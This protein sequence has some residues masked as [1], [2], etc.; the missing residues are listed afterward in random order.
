MIRFLFLTCLFFL[1]YCYGYGN[2][3]GKTIHGYL[4]DDN[5]E[6]NIKCGEEHYD[7]TNDFSEYKCKITTN[8]INI[9]WS[10]I[11][12]GDCRY[13]DI[14]FVTKGVFYIE[15]GIW[16]ENEILYYQYDNQLKNWFLYKKVNK[17]GAMDGPDSDAKPEKVTKL[18]EQWS[19]D[20]QLL[21]V[22]YAENAIK[23]IRLVKNKY[24][25]KLYNEILAI[26]KA[27]KLDTFKLTL[28]NVVEYNNLAF[29][30]QQVGA[31]TQAITILKNIITKFPERDVAYL[32]LADAY[33]SINS[34]SSALYNYRKYVT[35]MKEANKQD[36]IPDRVWKYLNISSKN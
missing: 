13:Y 20:K 3:A 11:N 22:T 12:N 9:N 18:Q 31:N 19:I 1:S 2:M 4:D 21:K 10:V 35:L 33:Q 17:Y 16:G 14:G 8:K 6:D 30:Y 15:C 28:K 24:D 7:K 5:R 34:S 32:N 23:F 26:A 36:K 25:N 27:N 29:Y